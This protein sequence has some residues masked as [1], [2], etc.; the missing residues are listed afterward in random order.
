MKLALFDLDGTLFDTNDVN[1]YAYKKALE[2]YNYSLDYDF[3]VKECNG[4]NYREFLPIVTNY[5]SNKVCEEIHDLKKN[6]YTEFLD[7]AKINK[8]LFEIIVAL[9]KSKIKIAIVTNASR[10]NCLEILTYFN[11]IDLFD[12]IV[13]PN[14]Y[15]RLKPAPDGF[16]Y[17]I[18][19][20][21]VDS[22]ET[23]IFEDSNVGIESAT[24]TG[25]NVFKVEQF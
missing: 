13:T 8:A 19:Y 5:S 14:D 7:K 12:L 24:A 20:F 3:Y 16:L 2:V 21:N 15:E 22:K 18:N 17:A 23:I 1:Y 10:Q 4:Q 9:K 25:A 6:L 11:K